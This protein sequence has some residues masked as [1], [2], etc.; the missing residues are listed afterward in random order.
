MRCARRSG[1]QVSGPQRE[2]STGRETVNSL[3]EEDC[4]VRARGGSNEGS[5][6]GI[7]RRCT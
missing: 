2:C 1:V 5:N 4:I 3:Y 7:D 6:G